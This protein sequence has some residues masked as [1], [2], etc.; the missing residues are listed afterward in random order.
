MEFRRYYKLSYGISLGPIKTKTIKALDS[1]NVFVDN[2]LMGKV[3]KTNY[4]GGISYEYRGLPIGVNKYEWIHCNSH[5]DLHNKL[6]SSLK[7]ELA[8]ARKNFGKFKAGQYHRYKKDIAKEVEIEL[9]LLN[10]NP[11]VRQDG[12][13]FEPPIRRP[14]NEYNGFYANRKQRR[15][16]DYYEQEVNQQ[17]HHAFAQAK[18]PISIPIPNLLDVF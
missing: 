4:N 13:N 11:P 14:K 16:R 2:K 10:I 17:D 7:Q 18:E 12:N 15:R 9:A 1:C 3:Y 5:E 6:K 8:E